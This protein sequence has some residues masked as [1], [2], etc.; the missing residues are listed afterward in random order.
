MPAWQPAANSLQANALCEF[1]VTSHSQSFYAIE[2]K[3][4]TKYTIGKNEKNDIVIRDKNCLEFHGE[5]YYERGHWIL[6]SLGEENPIFLNDKKLKAS[7]SL[8]KNDKIRIGNKTIYWSNY[9]YEGENQELNLKDILSI[10]G[11]ISKSNFRAL[12]LLSV[13]L[14][15]CV[16]FLPGLLASVWGYLYKRKFQDFDFDTTSAI[17]EIA[18]F[19]YVVGFSLIGIL[20]TIL[21]IKRIRDTGNKLW[22]II[23]PIYNLK[24]LY[25]EESKR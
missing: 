11:R 22:K 24:I 20:L 14:V 16:F 2:K 7:T 19:V 5:I 6:K 21:A 13:G 1:A 17:Q 8:N 18:P 23:I 4:K 3:M 9:L 12:S 25:F 15:I 10:N